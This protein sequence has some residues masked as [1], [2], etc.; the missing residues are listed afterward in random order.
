MPGPPPAVAATRRG[1]RREAVS[2]SPGDLVLVACSGGADSLA[3]AAAAAFELPRRDVRVGAVIVDHGLQPGSGDIADRAAEQCRGL[4]L[5][6][7]VI[8]R[9]AVRDSGTGPEAAARVARYAA[10]ERV[11]GELDASLVLLGHTRDDQAEQVLLGLA[12]GSG[13]RSL[14]GMP[15]RRGILARPLLEV[16]GVET[17]AACAHEGLAP[18]E[19][20]HNSDPAY[21]R[22]RARGLLARLEEGLGPGVAAALARSADQLREDA[23]HLDALAADAVATLGEAPWPVTTLL[24]LSRP[25]RTRVLRTLLTRA[26]APAGQVGSRHTD[27]VDAL[28]TDWR[29]QGPIVVPG[30]LAV[31]RSGDRLSIAP[32]PR[33]E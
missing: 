3:L 14:S 7:V 26:G 30:A 13:A 6:P 28:L 23:D 5:D 4:G 8:E 22:V 20:P 18:W 19:D 17:L 10:L 31:A 1:V 9:V 24:A 12:R 21:A 33:V 15:R 11:A 27:A 16:T 32:A 2:L 25:V 29:G